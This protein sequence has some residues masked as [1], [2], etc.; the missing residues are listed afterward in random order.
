ML[1]KLLSVA[2]NHL[3]CFATSAMS[4]DSFPTRRKRLLS[5]CH[6]RFLGLQ[7]FQQ[8][9]PL[10]LFFSVG[11]AVEAV[12]L[13]RSGRVV[14][15]QNTSGISIWCLQRHSTTQPNLRFVDWTI[16][17]IQ[18]LI[19]G[20]RL[21]RCWK[22][23]WPRMTR[24]SFAQTTHIETLLALYNILASF[25]YVD[26]PF[27]WE[28]GLRCRHIVDWRLVFWKALCPHLYSSLFS[29]CTRDI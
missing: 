25:F 20:R 14:E 22:G 4:L 23:L 5:W 17:K 8:I 29:L 7:R 11:Q 1:K 26:A 10:S 18:F 19:H 15:T 28:L 27:E 9:S 12:L 13:H 3:S 24:G 16:R 21:S 2:I 6:P